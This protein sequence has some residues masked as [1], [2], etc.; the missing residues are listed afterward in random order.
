MKLLRDS[1]SDSILYVNEELLVS[2]VWKTL[3]AARICS[4]KEKKN[5]SG[6]GL[7]KIHKRY[8]GLWQKHVRQ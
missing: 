7:R 4:W 8:S 2:A 6:I 1:D 5:F 3:C